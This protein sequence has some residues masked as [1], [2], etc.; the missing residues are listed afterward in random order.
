MNLKGNLKGFLKGSLLMADGKPGRRRKDEILVDGVN[1]KKRGGPTRADM[2]K[3]RAKAK[4]DKETAARL[5]Q[6]ELMD[7]LQKRMSSLKVALNAKDG[8]G[9][10]V[11]GEA[12]VESFEDDLSRD[13]ESKTAYQMLQ[14]MRW[15]YR[16][17]KGK[18]KLKTLMKGDDKLFVNMA[19]E[20]MKIEAQMIAAK[21]RAKEDNPTGGQKTVFVVLKGLHDDITISA[22][23]VQGGVNL[24]QVQSA[25]NPNAPPYEEERKELAPEIARP[26]DW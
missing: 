9:D 13:K 15:V 8:L 23:V 17:L 22:G 4:R 5:K 12:E 20:L 18:E 6:E 14:D 26:E 11:G 7:R 24:A 2:K 10:T 16:Q 3:V 25:I 1:E 19:K 21:I